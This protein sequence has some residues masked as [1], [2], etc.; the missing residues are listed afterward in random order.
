MTPATMTNAQK[1][2]AFLDTTSKEIRNIVL[3]TIA[4]HY[5]TTADVILDEV[6]DPEAEHLLDY[7]VE[8]TR[9]VVHIQMRRQQLV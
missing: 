4:D 5:R 3:D 7:M 9:S 2:R 6:I 8:P 1:N